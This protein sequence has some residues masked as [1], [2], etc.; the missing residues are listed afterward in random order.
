[1]QSENFTPAAEALAEEFDISWDTDVHGHGGPVQS[2]FPVFQFESIK[3]YFDGWASLGIVTPDDPADGVKSGA[4]NVP[5][6]LD[7]KDETRSYA[8]SAHYDRVIPSRPNYHLLPNTAVSK[9]IIDGD[10]ATGIRFIDRESGKTST[11][12]ARKEVILAAGAVHSPQILQLS[13]IGPKDL[14]DSLGV[15][16]KVNIPGVGHN[17]QDQPTLY[18]AWNFTERST[19][20][21]DTLY[22]DPDYAASQLDLYW[23]KRQGSFTIVN[24]GGNIVTF[25]PLPDVTSDYMNVIDQARE[26]A[27]Y[28]SLY[29][30]IPLEVLTGYEAQRESLLSLYASNS[31]SIQET[32]WNSGSVMPIT[33]LKPLSRGSIMINSTDPLADPVLD[34]ASLSVESD[35]DI[36]VAA[37][38]K[39]REFMATPAMQELGVI[40][41]TPGANV[42]MD[43]DLK[44]AFR[45]SVAPTYSHPCC[46][47]PMMPWDLGGVVAPDLSVYGVKGLRV[48]DASIMPIIPSAHLSATV[49]AVAEKAADI[50]K[51]SFGLHRED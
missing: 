25:L 46:T 7:P 1:M 42:T 2:S 36:L 44:A 14:L 28:P 18:S 22:Q 6:C 8:R 23:E 26:S 27:D 50:I 9:I 45:D 38:R 29:P 24:Q 16:T 21:T 4:F 49:Y 20:S 34:W 43:E 39:N 5:S 40:E 12:S 13:G 41:L 3:N 31:T 32:G 10:T 48:V 11:V 33:L 35:L 37:F 15:E 19:P 17:F 47:C 30:G 51:R